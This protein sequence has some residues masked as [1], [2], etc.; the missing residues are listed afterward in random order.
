[1]R[2]VTRWEAAALGVRGSPQALGRRHRAPGGRVLGRSPGADRRLRSHRYHDRR[3]RRGRGGPPASAG[4]LMTLEG[5][6]LAVMIDPS[7]YK[8]QALDLA[9][10]GGT[11]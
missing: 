5:I 3:R 6:A 2:V 7:G 8:Y 11:P 4:G 9:D 1:M 10:D